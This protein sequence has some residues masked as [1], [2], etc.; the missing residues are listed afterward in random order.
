MVNRAGMAALLLAAILA[1]TAAAQEEA[2]R[3]LAPGLDLLRFDVDTRSAHPDGEVHVLRI[4]P[5]AWRL[6]VLTA[7]RHADGRKRTLAAWGREFGLEAAVNAGMYQSDDATH[8]G[9]C[10][11][12]GEV[13]N[14]AANNYLSAFV[15]DPVD[16]V[17][18]P[19]AVVDLDET[20]LDVL[21]L[22]YRT[23]VQNLRLIK[24]P[25]RNRWSPGRDRWREAALAED[26]R[27]RALFILCT[28]PLAM[29]EFNEMLL[30]LPAG[31]DGGPAPGGLGAG[32]T[33]GAGAGGRLGP[34]VHQGFGGAQRAG[35]AG[36]GGRGAGGAVKNI[37]LIVIDTLRPDRLGCYGYD[38]PTPP[39]QRTIT[40]RP[41]ATAS[42]AL[43]RT[44]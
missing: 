44:R 38:R 36:A 12:D 30:A 7:S 2:V 17:D 41:V 28:R 43:S 16:T 14:G 18:A 27:G 5:T 6:A 9:F 29:H 3:S 19:F 15:C 32:R 20:P 11:V 31:R 39:P 26:D 37:V 25:G 21:R 34:L 10:Q 35:G 23:V 24:H 4:D 8:V 13:L 42:P 33:V 40:T 1:G 22:R